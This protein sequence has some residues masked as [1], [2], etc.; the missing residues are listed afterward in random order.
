MV[1]KGAAIVSLVTKVMVATSPALNM[2]L[3]GALVLEPIMKDTKTGAC[4]S[5]TLKV[6]PAKGELSLELTTVL[7]TLK[8]PLAFGTSAVP[9]KVNLMVLVPLPEMAVTVRPFKAP[10]K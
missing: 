3:L 5:P 8:P 2:V 1:T 4:P 9:L 7:V 10:V 6:P